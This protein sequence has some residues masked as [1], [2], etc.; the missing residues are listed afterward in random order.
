MYITNYVCFYNDDKK[1]FSGKEDLTENAKLE[2]KD[3]IYREDLI[4]A[5]GIVEFDEHLINIEIENIYEKMKHLTVLDNILD[6]LAAKMMSTD[7]SLGF[8]ILFSYDYF[9][10][11]HQ[12]ICEFLEKNTINDSKVAEL[13]SVVNKL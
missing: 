13:A 5:F 2:I 7:R 4:N 11:T 9:Y 6:I 1:M 12:I 10:L 3:F 8:L